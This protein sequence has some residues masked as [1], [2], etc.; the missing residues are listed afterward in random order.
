MK[1]GL[2]G[3][4]LGLGLFA[5]GCGKGES[6]LDAGNDQRTYLAEARDTYM[7]HDEEV[8]GFGV[9]EER[10]RDSIILYNPNTGREESMNAHDVSESHNHLFIDLGAYTYVVDK[11]TKQLL[12]YGAHEVANAGDGHIRET[13][14]ALVHEV[15]PPKSYQEVEGHLPRSI[16]RENTWLRKY[17]TEG[18]RGLFLEMPIQEEGEDEGGS[19]YFHEIFAQGKNAVVEIGAMDYVVNP[20]TGQLL[21]YGGHDVNSQR[22]D[23]LVHETHGALEHVVRPP[24]SY[25]DLESH[26]EWD[27]GKNA[28]IRANFSEEGDGLY[29]QATLPKNIFEKK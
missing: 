3:L 22:E 24:K 4:A 14:G 21:N 16:E 10:S 2:A 5:A 19:L 18:D 12:N 13:H 29:L 20:A 6:T 9:L 1:K 28:W 15:I 7:P 17:F 23:G 26:L 27:M 11:D 25:E 8:K